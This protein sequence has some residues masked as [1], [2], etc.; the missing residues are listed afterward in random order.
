MIDQYTP[1]LTV[2]VP[3]KAAKVPRV[4]VS[5]EMVIA[6]AEVT[7]KAA[8]TSDCNRICLSSNKT[9]IC[10]RLLPWYIYPHAMC[11]PR[12]LIRGGWCQF[13]KCQLIGIPS[14]ILGGRTHKFD[15]AVHVWQE[16]PLRCKCT[17][18]PLNFPSL[19]V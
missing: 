14:A 6:K 4:V 13:T 8:V 5:R 2:V 15:S 11:S 16:E 18:G 9:G 19:D 17:W 12:G 1:G 10:L 3:T 7:S